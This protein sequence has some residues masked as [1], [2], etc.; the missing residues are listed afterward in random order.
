MLELVLAKANCIC[1][2][3]FN[4]AVYSK[5]EK[6]LIGIYDRITSAFTAYL[7]KSKVVRLKVDNGKILCL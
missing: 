1:F 5:F 6:S 2:C 7:D 3:Q 4:C